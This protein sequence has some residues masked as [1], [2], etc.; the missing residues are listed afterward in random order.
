MALST[1]TAQTIATKH[2]DKLG[3]GAA[4]FDRLPKESAKA[5]QAFTIY[6]DLP[7]DERSLQM[8][9]QRLGKNRSLCARWSAQFQWMDRAKAWDSKQD[10]IRRTRLAAEREKM[11]DRQLQSSHRASQALM[12]PILAFLKRHQANADM[13]AGASAI[14]LIKAMIP[15]VNKLPAIQAEE[16]ML[17][18]RPD[19]VAKQDTPLTITSAEF[20]W[21]QGR[22]TCGHI[23][24]SHEQLPVELGSRVQTICTADACRCTHFR[25]DDEGRDS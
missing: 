9:S 18:A 24:D 2:E 15:A 19:E 23:W 1:R 21:V 17:M 8:V 5:F 6:R 12:V 3:A 7:I 4:T 10:Q 16:R 11:F 22:C 13:F 20:T 25:D 14:E